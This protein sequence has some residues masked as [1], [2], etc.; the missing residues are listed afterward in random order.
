MISKIETKDI[1]YNVTILKSNKI[2]IVMGNCLQIFD[3]N[4][5]YYYI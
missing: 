1:I 2:L 3:E 5:F 4:D